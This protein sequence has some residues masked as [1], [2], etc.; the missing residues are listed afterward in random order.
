MEKGSPSVP[1]TRI[2]PS[3][4]LPCIPRTPTQGE[5][6]VFQHWPSIRMY[7]CTWKLPEKVLWINI[8]CPL[9][10]SLLVKVLSAFSR[11][12]VIVLSLA[13]LHS[14]LC[15]QNKAS[16]TIHTIS[17]VLQGAESERCVRGQSNYQALIPLL[18]KRAEYCERTHDGG[19]TFPYPSEWDFSYFWG[20][21]WL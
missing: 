16:H 21:V 14:V 7:L 12:F 2:R 17:K 5:E 18:R 8:A 1:V 10:F 13:R 4:G 6:K 3:R 19:C 15:L 11:H 20:D 9:L